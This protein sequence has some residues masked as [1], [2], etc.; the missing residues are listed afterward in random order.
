MKPF[1]RYENIDLDELGLKLKYMR[2][3]SYVLKIIIECE[4]DTDKYDIS[5]HVIGDHELRTL[6]K[7]ILS[8]EKCTATS[9][10]KEKEFMICLNSA[11]GKRSLVYDYNMASK[12]SE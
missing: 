1:C 8:T 6:L 4:G 10:Q 2:L 7:H 3:L 5:D 12:R 11:L 9:P